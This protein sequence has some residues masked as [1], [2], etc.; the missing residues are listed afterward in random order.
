MILGAL[1][2]A[3]CLRSAPQVPWAQ[4]IWSKPLSFNAARR[5]A[6][7]NPRNP[8]AALRTSSRSNTK[9]SIFAPLQNPRI[10]FFS[11]NAS[12]NGAAASEAL[13]VL[14]SRSV[15]FWLL[16]SST[17]VFAIIVV[18]GVTRL[19]E[20]GLSI[21]EWRPITGVLPPLTHD[22]WVIEFDKYKATPE[23]KMCG[24][25]SVYPWPS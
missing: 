16:A 2:R 18:G 7:S 3:T 10:R 9:S 1:K 5:V 24:S 6:P 11:A 13:P 14:S 17:L 19:T 4:N 15:G 12:H 20:S 23:F 8:L 22:E 25:F 21:T